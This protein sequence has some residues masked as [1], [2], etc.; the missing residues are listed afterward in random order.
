MCKGIGGLTLIRATV[1][2]A[3]INEIGLMQNSRGEKNRERR[4]AAVTRN[5]NTDFLVT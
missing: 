2:S 4:R 5:S 3:R 1:F